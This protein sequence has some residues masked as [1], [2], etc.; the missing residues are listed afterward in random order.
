MDDQEV[1][2]WADEFVLANTAKHFNHVQEA[3]LGG[4]WNVRNTHKLLKTAI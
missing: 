1:L 2:N 4:T 3:I